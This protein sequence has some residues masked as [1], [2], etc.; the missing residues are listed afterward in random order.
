MN[1]I[2]IDAVLTTQRDVDRLIAHLR[3]DMLFLPEKVESEDEY[4]NI[5]VVLPDVLGKPIIDG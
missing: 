1:A 2:K 4:A 3:A 5:T